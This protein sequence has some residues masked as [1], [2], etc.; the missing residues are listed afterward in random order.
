MAFFYT[1]KSIKSIKKRYC[2][3]CGKQ[4]VFTKVFGSMIVFAL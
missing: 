3:L 2:K 1:L 4:M